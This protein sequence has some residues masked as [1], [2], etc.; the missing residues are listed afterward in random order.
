[1]QFYS[2]KDKNL[3]VSLKE[4]VLQG[5]APDG[6]LFMPLD[7][8]SFNGNFIKSL[9]GMSFQEIAY[10]A[11]SLFSEGEIPESD[12]KHIVEDAFNFPVVVKSLSD[13]LAVLELFH[14]PTLAFKD[15]GARFTSRLMS[16]FLKGEK[17]EITILVATSGDTGS[18]V[19]NGFFNT[20]GIKVVLLYPSGKVSNIQE[21]QLTTIGGNVTALE[22]EGTF[23][24]CQ[25][26]VKEAFMDRELSMRVNLS[27]ANS[28]NFA[29]LLPQSFYYVYAWSKLKTKDNEII[30]SVP[31]GNLGNLTA[32][33]MASEMGL[34]VKRFIGAV[35][36]NSVLSD[37]ISSGK[38]RVRPS[39]QTISNA[40]DVGNPSNIARI[41]DLYKDSYEKIKKVIFSTS[42][43]DER[44]R[45]AIAE[46]YEYFSY[47]IDPHGA[48]A[49][50]A[51]MEYP[52]NLRASAVSVILETAHPAK[53]PEVIEEAINTKVETPEK[54]RD[55]LNKKK[56]SVKISS[57]YPDLKQFLLSK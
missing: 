27:S 28:I 25:R 9:P 40:M 23:D 14:G 54:L 53:F 1:M 51:L 12:L 56:E 5:I 55:A 4:A 42:I 50:E 46:V 39:V 16:Y 36:Q 43:S 45:K 38:L 41:F 2:T 8:P 44:T 48:V 57:S 26:L 10:E 18:A 17:K 13:S 32:G 7:I 33:L 30:F 22:V 35:N 20:E 31:S 47:I 52:E 11:A 19:A 34:P 37:Y 6:G 24:D 29:R 49:Y 15:F 3:R 21:H